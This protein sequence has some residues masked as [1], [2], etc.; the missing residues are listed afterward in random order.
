MD[1][2][3]AHTQGYVGSQLW[4]YIPTMWCHCYHLHPCSNFARIWH[5]KIISITPFRKKS[6]RPPLWCR[7]NAK[8]RLSGW[9][10]KFILKKTLKKTKGGCV[11]FFGGCPVPEGKRIERITTAAIYV[12]FCGM[13][14]PSCNVLQFDV[15]CVFVFLRL[16]KY[17]AVAPHLIR[18]LNAFNN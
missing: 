16:K 11:F 6:F 7:I 8:L 15:F 2:A 12:F 5:Q 4:L 14:T 9:N 13:V 18:L 1:K 10:A 17:K 3:I